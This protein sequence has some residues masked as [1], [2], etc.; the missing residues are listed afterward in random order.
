MKPALAQNPP[1]KK[2]VMEINTMRVRLSRWGKELLDKYVPLNPPRTDGTQ[3]E[4]NIKLWEAFCKGDMDNM[5]RLVKAGAN[6]HS[7][8]RRIYRKEMGLPL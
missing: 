2:N 3:L 7:I 8:E 5:L 4:L 1:S 6:P